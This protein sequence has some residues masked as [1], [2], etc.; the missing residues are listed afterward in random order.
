MKI[1]VVINTYNRMRSLPDTL[2]SLEL[3]RYPELEIIV[4]DGPST[5]GTMSYLKSNWTGKIKIATCSE[6]N[7]SK[8]RNVGIAY[9]S[10]DIVCFTD[11]DGMPEPNWLDQIA[12]AYDDPAV[13]AVGGWVR[14]HTGVAYQTK[15]IVSSR[16]ATSEVLID[17][18]GDVPHCQPFCDKFPALIGVNSSFRRSVLLEIG[19]F[20]EEYA[21]FLDE[22]DVIV[23]LIDA[24]YQV[25]ILPDAEVH[26]KY[27]PSHIRSANGTAR[28]WLQIM[29]STAYY[30]VKNANPQTS[31]VWC[32]EK[33]FWHK[34]NLKTHTDWYLSEKMIDEARHKQLYEEI[35]NGA[36]RGISDAFELPSRVLLQRPNTVEWLP[37]PKTLP[38][39]RRLRICFVSALYPPRP[40]GGIAVFIF[41]LAKQLA[42]LGHE[43][44]VITQAEAGRCHTVDLEEGIWVH[45]LPMDQ[46]IKPEEPAGM[47]DMPEQQKQAA[48]QVLAELDRVNKCRKFQY[49]L[50]TI[51]DMDLA[52][53]I[54]SNR[55]PV[56][57]YLVTSYRLM[58]DSKPEW[59]ENA[60]YYDGH[61]TKMIDAEK[62]GLRN[63]TKILAS[64]NAI[65]LDTES[66][67]SVK[68]DPS[69]LV[70][71]PFGIPCGKVN[72]NMIA[73]DQ[74]RINLLFVGR[75]EHRKGADLLLTVLPE[76]LQKYESLHV[77][78]IGDNTIIGV[79]GVSYI[80][81][82]YQKYRSAKWLERAVFLGHVDDAVL[83][84][85]YK[86]CDFFVA[87][88]RYE[89][90]GLIYLEAMRYGKP[91]I[92][93]TAGGIP[94]VVTHEKTGLLVTPGETC[95]LAVAIE[96]LITDREYRLLL[97]ENA[98]RDYKERFTT[99]KFAVE[100]EKLMFKWVAAQE[101]LQQV[102]SHSIS[103]ETAT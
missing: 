56:A 7:L 74:K 50:G 14:N 40:C 83:E 33:I 84:Q 38:A 70:T 18:D 37:F 75:F 46:A 69:K 68:I 26:H 35:E 81:D 23:R 102:E 62:W 36:Q 9:A 67:Y 6:A 1:S 30:I 20:D 51:W 103:I 53:I 12:I 19:G 5:D 79:D 60:S 93:T 21:Y 27:A 91:C 11:D 48:C 95:E 29:T 16:D 25:K 85:A 52:A 15:F 82:F 54:A 57:M 87:P 66:A 63:A 99:E 28:S 59:K 64:T 42:V 92:G 61:V 17:N 55:Y 71:L 78:C 58:E 24:G 3:L 49:V 44:T 97:G 10:G 2:R 88:S 32:M 86:D 77:T 100:I 96:K 89:S 41:H 22:T 47:P 94:E 98:Q 101:N 34:Q 4:V 90:F 13:G 73:A 31:L 8:S 72:Q 43:I 76:L 45:R 65:R 80:D 39:E